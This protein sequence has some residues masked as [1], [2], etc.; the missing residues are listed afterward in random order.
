MKTIKNINTNELA[1][2]VEKLKSIPLDTDEEGNNKID[3]MIKNWK[4]VK[5]IPIILIKNN[6]QFEIIDGYHRIFTAL[7]LK[8]QKLKA[9][10]LDDFT[11]VRGIRR[12]IL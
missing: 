3:N 10:I 7:K 1:S 8:E 6:L 2:K 4:K 12:K 9:I 5:E 11:V